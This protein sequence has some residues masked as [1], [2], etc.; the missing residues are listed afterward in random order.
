MQL[1]SAATDAF[2]SFDVKVVLCNV[3]KYACS[4]NE[5]YVETEVM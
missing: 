5:G 1:R 3:K 4:G 2:K